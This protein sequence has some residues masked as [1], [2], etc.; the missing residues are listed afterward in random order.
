MSLPLYFVFFSFS[1]QTSLLFSFFFFNDTATTEIYPLSLHDALPISYHGAGLH[2]PPDQRQTD[3][4]PRAGDPGL[5]HERQARHPANVAIDVRDHAPAIGGGGRRLGIEQQ[6]ADLAVHVAS[7]MQPRDRLLA[8]VAALCIRHAPDL[9]EARF[10]GDG[11]VVHLGAEARPAREDAAQLQCRGAG[12]DRA[13]G[14]QAGGEQGGRC[15]RDCYLDDERRPF[16]GPRGFHAVGSRGY[17]AG[18][19]RHLEARRHGHRGRA[20]AGQA[21]D[22][23]LGGA[24]AHAGEARGHRAR[25]NR[26]GALAPPAVRRDGVAHR[27]AQ[28]GRP[29]VHH[30][31][32]L[33]GQQRAIHERAVTG[34]LDVVRQQSLEG[35]DGPGAR[36]RHHSGLDPRDQRAGI[37]RG[38]ERRRDVTRLDARD[39][40]LP[41]RHPSSIIARGLVRL[42]EQLDRVAHRGRNT[43]GGEPGAGPRAPLGQQLSYVAHAGRESLPLLRDVDQ[44]PVLLQ[45]RPAPRAVDDDGRIVVAEGGEVGAREPS[46]LVPQ[47]GVR[48][49]RA[50]ANLRRGF[51]HRVA[52]HL[53]RADRGVMHVGEEAFHYA[54]SKK[55]DG[56]GWW[57]LVEVGGGTSTPLHRPPPTSTN[58]RRRRRKHSH[59]EP[60]TSPSR[61]AA[62]DSR[63]SHQPREGVH[64]AGR[65]RDREGPECRAHQQGHAAALRQQRTSRLEPATVAHARRTDWLASTAAET[66]VE[67]QG[68]ARIGG[69]GGAPPPRAPPPQAAPPGGRVVPRSGGRG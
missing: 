9:V 54:T 18:G 12:R 21:I 67:V 63:R 41:L 16:G 50:T 45:H 28:P 46:R 13:G 5:R 57:R 52:V 32:P 44:V 49:Q 59:C 22:G 30:D 37:Q 56:G 40:W 53:Q 64:D 65:L 62:G 58:L 11:S 66:A 3:P 6:A 42:V 55:Q 43:R 1:F 23:Y 36:E 15:R 26:Q 68:D 69:G 35:R 17:A 24:V 48:V 47:T 20:R 34:E 39:L 60:D 33:G 31:H 14:L 2:L 61:Q 10:L 19:G 4:A 25:E 8:G 38:D 27:G 51:A 7:E 29:A